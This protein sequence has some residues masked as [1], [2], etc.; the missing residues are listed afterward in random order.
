M[1]DVVWREQAAKMDKYAN[2]LKVW[3]KSLRT[4]YGRL[5]KMP[6][7]SG[8]PQLSERDMDPAEAR[9][10]STIHLCYSKKNNRECK[11]INPNATETRHAVLGL[12]CSD[13]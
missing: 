13:Q 4:R 9:V 2:E 8:V 11:F 3:C 7:G 12:F 5:K 10:S 1:K 6:S